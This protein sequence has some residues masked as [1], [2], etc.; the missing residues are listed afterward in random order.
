MSEVSRR[1]LLS[2]LGGG[3]VVPP[4]FPSTLAK[5]AAI[6]R[7]RNIVF[8]LGAKLRSALA[9]PLTTHRKPT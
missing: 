8:N 4:A 5:A 2:A 9:Q 7:Q 3:A 1:S 6:G